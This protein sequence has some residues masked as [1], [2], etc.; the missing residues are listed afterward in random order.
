MLFF[1][2][3]ALWLDRAMGKPIHHPIPGLSHPRAGGGGGCAAVLDEV[4]LWGCGA[5]GHRQ[6]NPPPFCI[7]AGMCLSEA[8]LDQAACPLVPLQ[9]GRAR[10]EAALHYADA[11]GCPQEGRMLS[12]LRPPSMG[13]WESPAL[14]HGQS[15][16]LSAFG[17]EGEAFLCVMYCCS[18]HPGVGSNK[19]ASCR[20][21]IATQWW[22]K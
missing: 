4:L 9:G 21:L 3:A 2:P 1:G 18:L 10:A 5:V 6:H 12:S 20:A 17:A 19:R 7:L 11:P 22:K 15:S 16:C 14:A 8:I 13:R